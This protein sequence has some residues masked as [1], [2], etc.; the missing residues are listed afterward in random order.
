[1]TAD[2]AE[3]MRAIDELSDHIQREAERLGWDGSIDEFLDSLKPDVPVP[4]RCEDY[5]CCGHTDGLG[6]NYD[7]SY[8]SSDA[9]HT[10]LNNHYGCDHEAGWCAARDDEED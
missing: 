2:R 3:L 9:Y 5:P 10:Y 6:C 1:M 8:Y 7:T 4:T